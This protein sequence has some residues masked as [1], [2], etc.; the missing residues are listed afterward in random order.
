MGV[1]FLG[2]GIAFLRQLANRKEEARPTAPTSTEDDVKDPM[3]RRRTKPAVWL[4]WFNALVWFFEILTGFGL[5]SSSRYRVTPGFYNEAIQS[6]FGSPENMLEFHIAVGIAWLVVLLAYATFGFKRYLRT[7]LRSLIF[8]R[9][10]IAWLRI[11][12]SQV[13]FKSSREL[14][15]QGMYNAGQKLFGLVVTS[16]TLLSIVSGLS[17]YLLPGSG[18][19]VRWAIPIHFLAAAMVIVGL[20]VH[21]YMSLLVPSERPALFS[22]FHGRVPESY[23]KE[24]NRL[25]WEET[26]QKDHSD[27][28]RL[29]K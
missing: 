6:I 17:M 12:L 2:Q 16:G 8:S 28:R 7:F 23:A 27:N 19:L 3:L 13:F 4:H 14:P 15:P 5:L 11:R 18:A 26:K 9:E 25:W 1:S 10:D 24:H 21:I 20:V 22:M 29:S